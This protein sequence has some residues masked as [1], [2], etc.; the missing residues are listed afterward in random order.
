[1][2]NIDGSHLHDEITPNQG[3][4]ITNIY[5]DAPAPKVEWKY[6]DSTVPSERDFKLRA[7]DLTVVRNLK[8]IVLYRDGRRVVAFG[9]RG[10]SGVGKRTSM[11][12][13]CQ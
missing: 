2:I 5:N 13:R 4:A 12:H 1:M 11:H 6:S 3:S 7:E 9:V 8:E 10:S